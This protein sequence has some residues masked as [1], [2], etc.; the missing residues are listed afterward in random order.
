MIDPVTSNESVEETFEM[1]VALGR[2]GEF[3]QQADLA[4]AAVERFA[5]DWRLKHLHVLSI[6]NAGGLTHAVELFGHH[7]LDDVVALDVLTL[8]ARLLKDQALAAPDATTKRVL[9]RKAAAAYEQAI[10]FPGA[11]NAYYPEDNAAQ[12]FLLAGEAG[13]AVLHAN[14][15]LKQL[16]NLPSG[17]DDERWQLASQLNALIICGRHGEVSGL[18]NELACAFSTDWAGAATTIEHLDRLAKYQGVD[19]AW[20]DQ[21]RPPPIVMYAGHIIMPAGQAGRFQ[22]DAEELVTS[23]IKHQ[24]GNK[25]F[26]HAYG[27]LAAGADII[28]AET[29][30]SQGRNITAV[31]PCAEDDFIKTSVA[32]SGDSWVNRYTEIIRNKNTEII[33]ATDEPLLA[34]DGLFAYCARICMGLTVLRAQHLKTTAE[35][36]AVWDGEPARGP[37]GTANDVALWHRKMSPDLRR[38]QTI[39]PLDGEAAALPGA[40]V[41]KEEEQLQKE[42]HRRAARAVLFGDFAG[43][44]KLRD[45]Q[46]PGFATHVLGTAS[47]VLNQ[48]TDEVLFRNTWGDGLYIVTKRAREA[49]IIAVEMQD[50]LAAFPYAEHGLPDTLKFRIGGHLGPV[51][52]MQDPV[53]ERSN[54]FGSQVSHAAR[55]EPVAPPGATYVSGYFAAALA[56][57]HPEEFKC[58]L[59]GTINLAKKYGATRV[60][61]LRNR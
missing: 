22:S 3:F 59:V 46:I 52:Q 45:S 60:F 17:G 29:M 50:A 19:T 24:L 27:S 40:A 14:N 12:L 44:S 48:Y 6:A 33:A 43:F 9:L 35:Q 31:L 41:V 58:D 28:F 51:F 23:K 7:K 47:K 13:R 25:Q 49:A 15:V 20:L 21:L 11:E 2:R 37:A 10:S 36:V 39:I 42:T 26:G 16:R 61:A 57:D 4:R 30:L 55:I 32:P 53:L 8:K 38:Q 54:F 34:D 18:V 5:D 1:L 56:L